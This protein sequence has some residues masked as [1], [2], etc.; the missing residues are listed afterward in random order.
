MIDISNVNNIQITGY[1]EGEGTV[2]KTFT[3]LGRDTISWNETVWGGSL[4]RTNTFALE[5]I[6]DVEFGTV[7]QL[8]IVFKYLSMDDFIVLQ[9]LLMQRH[10][11][12]RYFDFDKGA[13]VTHE[14][15]I[16]AN[17]RKKFYS[18]KNSLEAITDFTIKMV[19]T[20]RKVPN[21]DDYELG[22]DLTISYNKNGATTGSDKVENYQITD[23]VIIDDGSD[24]AKTG[25]HLKEWNTK[26][27]G[28]GQTY[29]P[30]FS[31]TLWQSLTL[32]AIWEA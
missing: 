16:T 17:E 8:T 27:D 29:Q 20:N 4:T 15:A 5:N 2:T 10:L 18:Y 24:Y 25:Y 28:T 32:Y 6:D 1:I 23:Q 9:K 12:V 3:N 14:M 21:T 30:S 7:P 31:M 13:R 11:I 19:G 26:A 22:I